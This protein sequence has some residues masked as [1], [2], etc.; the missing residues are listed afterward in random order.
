MYRSMRFS[1]LLSLIALALLF[2]VGQVV[3]QQSARTV[4]EQIDS[5]L[6][7]QVEAYLSVSD[8][9]GFPVKGLTKENFTVS[10]D[11][12]Q[13]ADFE[14]SSVQ[15]IQQPLAF[16][17]LIDT[18]GSMAWNTGTT[19]PMGDA[20]S[21]AKGFAD[22]LSEQ[23]QV[24]VVTFSSQVEVVQGLTSDKSTTNSALNS[25]AAGGDTALYDGLVEAIFQLKDVSDRK[26]VLLITDGIESGISDYTF[27]QAVNEAVR[28]SIPVY[29]IGFGAVDE[30]QLNQLA[31]LT[32]GY[33][34]VQPDS[35][36]LLNSL[37]TVQQILRE[38]YLLRFE[39]GLPADGSEH[40]LS[41]VVD[42]PN[43]RLEASQSFVAQPGEITVTLPDY[44]DGQIIGGKLRFA[45]EVISPAVV[46]SL[47]ISIDGEPLD[48]VLSEPFEYNWD[49]SSVPTGPHQ[50]DFVVE[51]S[52]GNQGEFSLTL[53]V[54]PAVTVAI[55]ALSEGDKVSVTTILSAT[56]TAQSAIAKVEFYIDDQLLDT[57]NYAPFEA[58]WLV[59]DADL[60]E[61]EIKVVAS[62][63]AGN[64]VEDQISVEVVEPITVSFVDLEDGD[65]LR[66]APDI[67]LQVENQFEI[68]EVVIMVNGEELASF[69]APPYEVEWPLYN[70]GP[71]EYVISAE[72]RDGDGHSAKAEVTVEVN[73]EAVIAGVE[74]ETATP[75]S[76][77]EPVAVPVG[78]TLS[79]NNSYVIWIVVIVVLAIA[80]III[81]L[82]LRRRKAS[83]DI[84]AGPVRS[85]VL[86]EVEGNAPGKAWRLTTAEVSLGRKRDE[87][88]IHLKGR[89]ASRR[90]AVIRA[91]QEGYTLYN[92]SPNNPA[93]VNGTPVHQQKLLQNGD[94]IQ[95]GES[96]F[97]FEG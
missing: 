54:E 7:P 21:A 55:D 26:V 93:V 69:T 19:V 87:N 82:I 46:S 53:I 85:A 70:V 62:D 5:S 2:F 10:E 23:D 77:T 74:D 20:I 89:S 31:E 65:L 28:W 8:V 36:T 67:K 18:S 72:A 3:A 50:F 4:I 38:Q 49:A 37:T 33:A 57:I 51:D 40:T 29:P 9:Q 68:D 76:D 60:G 78:T 39:S 24:A 47:Q 44:E 58:E 45:P 6:F 12:Q 32:G 1:W 81:P 80:G 41:V 59:E 14:I 75:G 64:V 95:M 34:Q 16:V 61:H 91:S 63:A 83:E 66:G 22:T 48:T 30:Q 35:S 90:M 73:R 27:D 15:N 17:L 79:T 42:Y 88:D 25:L 11:G 97:T 86:H 84:V 71:G 52:A 56:V 92:L 13:V 43:N 94:L 96:Q